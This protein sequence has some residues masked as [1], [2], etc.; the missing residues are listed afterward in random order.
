[1]IKLPGHGVD[2]PVGVRK[3]R[4]DACANEARVEAA[5]RVF[6]EAAFDVGYHEIARLAGV[7]VGTVFRRFPDREALLESVLVGIL[8][9][10]SAW[11][12]AAMDAD[13]PWAAFQSAFRRLAGS[14]R[15][16]AGLTS[17][18]GAHGAGRA[19]KA[20][21]ELLA[22]MRTLAG[23]ASGNGLRSDVTW[24]T[25][26]SLA[27]ASS[28]RSCMLDVPLDEAHWAPV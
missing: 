8:D 7:G 2:S 10:L 3:R 15:R 14:M 27:Q 28:L 21:E 25:I 24:R 13:D 20:R 22:A 17:A 11:M 16:H 4:A 26:I 6:A 23:R 9:E 19:K 18:F 5:R 12:I 1:M